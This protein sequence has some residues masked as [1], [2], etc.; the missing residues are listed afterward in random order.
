VLNV[1]EVIY[2]ANWICVRGGEKSLARMM[3][4]GGLQGHA[5]AVEEE[6]C[7]DYEHT[8]TRHL[9]HRQTFAKP[10][11]GLRWPG[12]LP[13]KETFRMTM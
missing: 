9:G 12:T 8:A 6:S 1:P 5:E 3:S 13:P 2:A 11:R 7:C 10:P 4:D